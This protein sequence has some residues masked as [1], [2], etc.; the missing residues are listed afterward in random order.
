[1]ILEGSAGA[2]VYQKQGNTALTLFNLFQ[3]FVT[4]ACPSHLLIPG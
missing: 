1:M 2:F 4:R 3:L